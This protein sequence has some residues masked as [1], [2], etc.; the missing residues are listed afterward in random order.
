MWATKVM[1]EFPSFPQHLT[2]GQV[3]HA[4]CTELCTW[5]NVAIMNGGHLRQARR[6]GRQPTLCALYSCPAIARFGWNG[7]Y[8]ITRLLFDPVGTHSNFESS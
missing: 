6:G 7:A 5:L 2:G 1:M 8:L 4:Q 3:A